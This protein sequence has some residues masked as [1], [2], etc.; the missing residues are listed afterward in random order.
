MTTLTN[1]TTHWLAERATQKQKSNSNIYDKWIAFADGQAKNKTLWY[2]V[3]MITQG[4]LFLPVPAVLIYYFNAPIIVLAV[5]L[6]LFF[7][8][9]IAG[10]GGEGIRTL[11]SLFAIS[12]IVHIL[13]LAIFL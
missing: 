4:V 7:A 3:S 10:M 8:N 13:M 5:T 1:T 12:V 2:M 6:T 11:T 9:I